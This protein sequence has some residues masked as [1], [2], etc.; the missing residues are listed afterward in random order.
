MF[1]VLFWKSQVAFGAQLILPPKEEDKKP[2]RP[3]YEISVDLQLGNGH[4]MA[5]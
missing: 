2:T 4:L 5:I 3:D 1:V